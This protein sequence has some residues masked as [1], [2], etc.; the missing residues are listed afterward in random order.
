MSAGERGGDYGGVQVFWDDLIAV[1]DKDHDF[2]FVAWLGNKSCNSLLQAFC[3]IGI[4]FM[5]EISMANKTIKDGWSMLMKFGS[6]QHL[7]KLQTGQLYMKN[8]KYYVNLEK[9]TD[10]E[11]VGDQ[12]DGHMVLQDVKMSM[13]TVDTH[14]FIAQF[15]APT[16]SMDLGYLECPVF[17]MFMFDYRN[18]VEEHLDRDNLIVKYQF[19]EKQLEKMPKFGDFVL[20]IK[21]GNE[22]INRVKKG[23]LNAGYGFTRDHV[24]YYGFNN[25]EHLRQVQKDNSRIAFWKREK[26][27]YQQEYRFLIHDFVDDYLSVDIGDI[28]DITDLFRTKELLNICVEITFKVKSIE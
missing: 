23:L 13:Y 26:Y 10:D 25:L 14:E 12:Y 18:H 22:F 19:T 16:T 9:T 2:E 11:D 4:D 15:D 21:N 5:E 24:Q 7:K 6:E 8:L 27:S 3:D 28:S 20:I 17:C 1:F